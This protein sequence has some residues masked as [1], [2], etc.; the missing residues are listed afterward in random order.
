MTFKLYVIYN[1]ASHETFIPAD[2]STG[3]TPRGLAPV[4]KKIK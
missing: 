4:T 3:V 1:R 2:F